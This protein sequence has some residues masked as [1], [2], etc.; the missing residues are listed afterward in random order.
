MASVQP[1]NSRTDDQLE[2]ILTETGDWVVNGRQGRVL[3]LAASLGRALER[4]EAYAASGAV[5]IAITRLPADNII[6]FAGQME[7]LR[8][9]IAGRETRSGCTTAGQSAGLASRV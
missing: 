4:A 7:R 2:A 1:P 9:R 3:C 6:V 5:V 8:R